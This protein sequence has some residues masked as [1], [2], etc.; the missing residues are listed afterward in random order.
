MTGTKRTRP[1][2]TCRRRKTKCYT[3]E[4]ESACVLCKFHGQQCTYDRSAGYTS[5]R[6]PTSQTV[7]PDGQ[8][9]RDAHGL[10]AT[11]PG[12]GVEEYDTLPEGTTLLKRTLGLQN[13]HHS[14]YL[15]VNNPLNVY[16]LGTTRSSEH[17]PQSDASIQ[18]RFVHPLHAFRIIPDVDT[19]AYSLE[20]SVRDAIEQ[21]V[22][23]H[24]PD[25]VSLYFR[26]N[27]LLRSWPQYTY[28]HQRTG[29]TAIHL[30]PRQSLT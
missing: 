17:D 26:M 16:G 11:I 19:S 15:G 6:R 20:S 4:R 13:L 5:R 12:T 29:S 2:D 8:S 30:L 10:H 7:R 14:Q 28:L 18:V 27:S 25:L 22:H 3:D 23:G 24:G 1:C 21:A 9:V